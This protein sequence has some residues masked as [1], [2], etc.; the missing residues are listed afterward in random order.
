MKKIKSGDEVIVLQTGET[1]IVDDYFD[2]SWIIVKVGRKELRLSKDEIRL[3]ANDEIPENAEDK[4][5]PQL[6]LR[7]KGIGLMF[8]AINKLSGE[9][10]YF[11]IHFY[12]H[13]HEILLIDYQY[14]LDQ[15]MQ[16]GFKKEVDRYATILLHEFKPDQL[17]DHPAF[18]LKC[19]LKNKKPAY[20]DEFEKEIRLKA[21]QYFAKTESDEFKLNGYFTLPFFSELPLFVEPKQIE[22][23]SEINE[24]GNKDIDDHEIILKANMPD[25]IDLHTENL[26]IDP[27][28]TDASE[29]L[30]IQLKAFEQFIEK[31]IRFKLH[32]IYVVHGLGKGVLKKEIEKKLKEYPQVVSFN[33]H[34]SPRFGFGATEIFLA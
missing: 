5:A 1:G 25:S 9:F 15:T 28:K 2:D 6:E 29:I 17:N 10:N 4:E 11:E 3:I 21:K 34:H 26:F 20:Q 32:K 33:N 16:Y 31:A 18:L 24:V 12:N 13:T 27:Q 8:K 23:G 14:Y 7:E 19:W 30:S 22:P